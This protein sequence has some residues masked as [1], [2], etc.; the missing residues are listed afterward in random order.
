M[1]RKTIMAQK[2]EAT[3][4]LERD[5]PGEQE[6]DLEVEQDEQDGDEVV[7]HVELHARVLEGLEAAFVGRQFFA[8]SGR[9]GPRM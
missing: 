1:P 9:L 6:G 3:D 8:G 5:G 2:P 7:A 4:L